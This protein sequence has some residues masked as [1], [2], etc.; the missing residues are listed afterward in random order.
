MLPNHKP[1]LLFYATRAP[2]EKK[3]T[4]LDLDFLSKH[5]LILDPT[6]LWT[7]HKITIF[8]IR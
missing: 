8:M 3:K 5:Y 1:A 7:E 4:T 6:T 2:L